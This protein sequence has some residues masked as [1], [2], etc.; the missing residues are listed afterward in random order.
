M[1]N[2]NTPAGWENYMRD[3]AETAR[4]EPL[5]PDAIARVAPCPRAVPDAFGGRARGAGVVAEDLRASGGELGH[6][7]AVG[8]VGHGAREQSV[9]RRRRHGRAGR[10]RLGL[11]RPTASP[12][13]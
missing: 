8:R 4:S 3:L 5:T 1:L 11:E 2:F 9:H 12:R 10:R 6:C 13:A 7:G